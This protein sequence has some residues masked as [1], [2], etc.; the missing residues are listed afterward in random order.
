MCIACPSRGALKTVQASDTDEPRHTRKTPPQHPTLAYINKSNSM[1]CSARTA[2]GDHGQKR[3]FNPAPHLCGAPHHH[4]STGPGC[5]MRTMPS[6]CNNRK[7]QPTTALAPQPRRCTAASVVKRPL[8]LLL[9]LVRLL[10][11]ANDGADDDGDSAVVASSCRCTLL[12]A[13]THP[14]PVVRTAN[15]RRWNH[16]RQGGDMWMV[17]VKLVLFKSFSAKL[18]ALMR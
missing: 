5:R 12:Q 13:S 11:A 4:W 17:H 14:A 16:N 9:V 15:Q 3:H 8:P 18:M 1:M 7:R 10:T 2:E 6:W